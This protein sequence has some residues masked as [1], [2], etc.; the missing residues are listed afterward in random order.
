[1]FGIYWLYYILGIVMIPGIAL[2]IWAQAKV[3][4]A[5]NAYNKVETKHGKTAKEVASLI[6]YLLSEDAGYI[7][8]QVI[9]VNGGMYQ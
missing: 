4:S 2:G 9:S 3:H 6:N 8:G 1:M 7:T 5:F